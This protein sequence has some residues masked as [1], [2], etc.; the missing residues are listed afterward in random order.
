MQYGEFIEVEKVPEPQVEH[1]R[2]FVEVPAVDTYVPAAQSDHVVQLL[3]FEPVEYEPE[4]QLAH[5]R[6]VVELPAVCT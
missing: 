3:W 6:L 4:A 5:T 2:L 1:E